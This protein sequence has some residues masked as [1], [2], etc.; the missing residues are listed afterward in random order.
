[1]H[2][3]QKENDSCP[4]LTVESHKSPSRVLVTEQKHRGRGRRHYDRRG[5]V[6]LTPIPDH[7]VTS[8]L[9]GKGQMG[10]P[11]ASP[12]AASARHIRPAHQCD[13]CSRQVE[14]ALPQNCPDWAWNLGFLLLPLATPLEAAATENPLAPTAKRKTRE[15]KNR[16]PCGDRTGQNKVRP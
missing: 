10:K 1:M 5:Q 15:D 2:Q 16:G 7:R 9:R 11:P 13:T 14:S 12:V 4:Q 8:E 3:R 6:E